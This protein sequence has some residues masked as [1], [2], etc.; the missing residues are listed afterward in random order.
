MLLVSILLFKQ[1]NYTVAII[2]L[3]TLLIIAGFRDQS[4]GTDTI[5]YLEHYSHVLNGLSLRTEPLWTYLIKVIVYFGGDFQTLLLVSSFLTLLPIFYVIYK[6]SPYPLLS[7]FL[8][9][10]LYYYFYSFNIIRQCIAM[11]FGL[12]SISQ[13]IDRKK[14]SSLLFLILAFLFHYSSIILLPA[15]VFIHFFK[16]NKNIFYYL[17]LALSFISGLFFGSN[18]L[19]FAQKYIYSDY[20]ID[21]QLNLLGNSIYLLIVNTV[22]VFVTI[23]IK[24]KDKWFHLFYMYVILLNLLSRIPFG[25][26]FSMF[27][28]ICSIIFIPLLLKNNRL[29]NKQEV[30]LVLV[31]VIV[32]A[33][34]T[35]FINWGNGGILPYNNVLF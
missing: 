35:L 29:K 18:L 22:F 24:E 25:N 1:K 11:S 9:V 2:Y 33:L 8:Y 4:V 30:F 28:G 26:R 34:F 32:M 21:Y 16:S 12:L 10:S 17:T 23:I 27:Y 13:L 6:K 5:N 19:D 20:I 7:I 31:S 3:V 15:F 14:I